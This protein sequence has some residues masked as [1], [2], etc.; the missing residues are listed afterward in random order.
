M[1]QNYIASVNIVSPLPEGYMDNILGTKYDNVRQVAYIEPLRN[2][3][4]IK[5]NGAYMAN[6]ES[7]E[8]GEPCTVRLGF[9]YMFWFTDLLEAEMFCAEFDGELKRL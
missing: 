4:K 9:K 6:L 8:M 2:I 1:E 7:L 3:G 5:V